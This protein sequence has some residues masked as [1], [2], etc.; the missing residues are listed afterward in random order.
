MIMQKLRDIM[1]G[2]VETIAPNATVQEAAKKMKDLR[3]GALPVCEG[4]KLIGIITDRDL[5]MR[6]LAEGRDPKTVIVDDAL[7]INVVFCFED[8]G[9]ERA[10]Q[11]M[12]KHQI[13]RLPVMSSTKRLVGIVTLGD[14]AVH[15]K[16]PEVSGDVLQQVSIPA[17]PIREFSER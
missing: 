10:S 7:T 3:V 4:D 5:V 9:V 2:N 11:L 1:T 14:L 6:V 16:N 13:R 8:E 17:R 12:A 15:G